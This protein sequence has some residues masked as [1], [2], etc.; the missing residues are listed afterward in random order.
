MKFRLQRPSFVFR[1]CHT[2]YQT[3]RCNIITM[4]CEN[5]KSILNLPSHPFQMCY[6]RRWIY[7]LDSLIRKTSL[8]T[9]YCIFKI[10]RRHT[11]VSH[12]LAGASLYDSQVASN[13]TNQSQSSKVPIVCMETHNYHL[14]TKH[15]ECSLT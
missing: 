2:E 1:T 8:E 11:S 5:L 3:W 4:Q 10:L 15:S 14:R 7:P 12:D 13:L 9:Q 6:N